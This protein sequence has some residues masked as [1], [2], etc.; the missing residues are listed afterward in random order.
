MAHSSLVAGRQGVL[1]KKCLIPS[2]EIRGGL[3]LSETPLIVNLPQEHSSTVSSLPGA[4][5]AISPALGVRLVISPFP[6]L[7]SVGGGGYR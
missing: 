5:T 6:T 7:S 4:E 3:G 1:P 2:A